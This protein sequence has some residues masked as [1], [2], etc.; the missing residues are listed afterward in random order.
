MLWGPMAIAMVSA[1][2]GLA[3][4][5]NTAVARRRMHWRFIEAGVR[6]ATAAAKLGCPMASLSLSVWHD[7]RVSTVSPVSGIIGPAFAVPQTRSGGYG[8][9]LPPNTL[10]AY[11]CQLR[12]RTILL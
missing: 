1:A 5:S 3:A 2:A 7:V 11:F 9:L 10:C 12:R 6:I 4:G 8:F